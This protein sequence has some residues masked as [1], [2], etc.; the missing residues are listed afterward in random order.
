MIFIA[1]LYPLSI[2]E[3]KQKYYKKKA[4]VIKAG[5]PERFESIVDGQLNSLK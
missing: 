4:L 5:D 1:I 2:E 3:F